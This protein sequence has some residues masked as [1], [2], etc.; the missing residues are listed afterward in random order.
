LILLFNIVGKAW[1]SSIAVSG[2]FIW[3]EEYGGRGGLF[4]VWR[5]VEYGVWVRKDVS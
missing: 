2:F 1:Y 5:L 3:N 4:W